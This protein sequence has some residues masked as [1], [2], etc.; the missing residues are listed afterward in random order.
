MIF[1]SIG[2]RHSDPVERRITGKP[3]AA[4]NKFKIHYIVYDWKPFIADY[5]PMNGYILLPG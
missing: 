5:D 3:M 2:M 4:N 1:H